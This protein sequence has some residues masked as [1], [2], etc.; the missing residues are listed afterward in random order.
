MTKYSK[1]KNKT[2]IEKL[3]SGNT[4][5]YENCL[6]GLII[7]RGKFWENRCKFSI[8]QKK[9]NFDHF[10]DFT[11]PTDNIL[12]ENINIY[13][14][15]LSGAGA[16]IDST[17][18]DPKIIINICE[19]RRK[20]GILNGNDIEQ[21]KFRLEEIESS[22]RDLDLEGLQ[23][24]VESCFDRWLDGRRISQITKE[25]SNSN[26]DT[27]TLLNRIKL[28]T[29]GI[30]KGKGIDKRGIKDILKSYN[31]IE[32]SDSWERMPIANL[33]ELTKAMG[34]GIKK[35]EAMLV[36]APP[37]GGKTTISC[38]IA[39][40]LVLAN[41]KVVYITTEQPD[42]ELFPKMLSCAA[43]IPYE[44]IRDGL[45]KK[46]KSGNLI[47]V[48]SK[49]E[50]NIAAPIWNKMDNK[51]F[52]ENW[53]DSGG[54]IRSQLNSTIEQYK[55]E[56]D[57]DVVIIDWIGGGLEMNADQG[58]L[59]RFFYD[60]CCNMIK[61]ACNKYNIAII[62]CSQASSKK[63]EGITAITSAEISECTMMHTYFTWALGISALGIN[64]K[65]NFNGEID[66][67]SEK[68]YFNLFKT[69]KSKGKLYPVLTDFGYSRF[70][71]CAQD[72]SEIDESEN[73]KNK[74][75]IKNTIEL[76][77]NNLS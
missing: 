67:T 48:L 29:D 16:I 58:D 20:E 8:N 4:G 46:D 11:K 54:K 15:A 33:H 60:D 18:L 17:S 72:V 24:L 61:D 40:G 73:I 50:L 12:Y 45:M 66:N 75:S 9:N 47:P 25:S 6:L 74:E 5:Y 14:G 39:V 69:R 26:I 41:R 65:K 68:Q 77:Q 34:G 13:Y 19:N 44:K 22:V 31:N 59:K 27:Q 1:P 51:L 23:A 38:Q 49:E 3:I 76:Y 62:A 36:I 42:T 2:D 57:I 30:V 21:I 35:K 52:F 10:C 28:A 7:K 56:Q 70:I 43:S 64:K 63:A 71:E 37:G 55:K 32:E 53:C